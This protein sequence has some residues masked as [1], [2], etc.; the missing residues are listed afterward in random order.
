MR[1]DDPFATGYRKLAHVPNAGRI[2]A[3]PTPELRFEGTLNFKTGKVST[4][5]EAFRSLLERPHQ[6]GLL[7]EC[8]N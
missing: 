1:D 8:L 4:G 2:Q 7:Q 6:A 5:P 3:A